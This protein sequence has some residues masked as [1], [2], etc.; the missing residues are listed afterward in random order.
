M[1]GEQLLRPRFSCP[2]AL[3]H[4]DEITSL[5]HPRKLYHGWGLFIWSVPFIHGHVTCR[6]IRAL[7]SSIA[8][9]NPTSFGL[10]QPHHDSRTAT[11]S[12]SFHFLPHYRSLPIPSVRTSPSPSVTPGVSFSAPWVFQAHPRSYPNAHTII[13]W[14]TE[15]F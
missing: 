4:Q 5:H 10:P 8:M 2:T 15:N 6:C 9:I 11:A 1:S 14:L 3:I 7:I 12:Q 13:P